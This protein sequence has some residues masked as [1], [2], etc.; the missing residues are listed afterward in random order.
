MHPAARDS[1]LPLRPGSILHMTMTHQSSK[2]P[3]ED[4]K[5]PISRRLEIRACVLLATSD[6]TASRS[7]SQ[8]KINE[9]LSPRRINANPEYWLEPDMCLTVVGQ[10]AS[11]KLV[12]ILLFKHTR[13]SGPA[14]S[15]LTV[16]QRTRPHVRST[17]SLIIHK[18]EMAQARYAAPLYRGCILLTP[19]V[20]SKIKQT[21]TH[22]AEHKISS[23]RAFSS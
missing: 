7:R 14:A 5:C 23:N 20:S 10:A 2:R 15:S 3:L 6:I 13:D 22:K 11:E 8:D 17:S 1:K 16:Y 4:E 21:T 12:N 18:G 9:D 19:N